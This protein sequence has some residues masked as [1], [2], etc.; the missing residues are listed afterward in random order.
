MNTTTDLIIH[1]R[2]L[3]HWQKAGATYFLTFRLHSSASDSISLTPEEQQLII[4][5]IL[6]WHKQKW[7]VY[8]AVV[9]S[10]HVH[11]IARPIEK[12]DGSI[13]LLPEILHSIKSFSANKIN[14]LRN[15]TG[16]LWMSETYD[17]I[18]RNEQEFDNAASYVYLNPYKLEL[19]KEGEHYQGYWVAETEE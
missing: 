15:R 6:F 13:Y 9:L 3:P 19:I 8:C 18:L 11:C 17:R 16:V 2:F 12:K 10:D 1:R 5:S 7:F 4:E 14:R